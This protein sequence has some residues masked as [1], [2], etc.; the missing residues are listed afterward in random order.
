MAAVTRIARSV[1]ALCAAAL[2]AS[3]SF[4]QAQTAAGAPPAAVQGVQTPD[5]QRFLDLAVSSA[6]L[7]AKAATLAAT[8]D[9]RPE[10]KTFAQAMQTFRDGQ[11]RRL[12]AFAQERSLRLPLVEQFEHK[13]LLENL[14]PLDLLALTRR[15]AELQIQALDQEIRIYQAAAQGQDDAVK[16]FAQ[17]MMPQLQQQL[18]G[19][20][21]VWDTVKP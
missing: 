11:L 20:R 15:Y 8:R 17:E 12:Q 19:A 14:E 7:Q 4:A 18:D 6:S 1:L 10:V 21:R 16:R 9:T 5:P 3:W 13:V 2:G